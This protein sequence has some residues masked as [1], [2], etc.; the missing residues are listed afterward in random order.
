LVCDSRR[1]TYDGGILR[2]GTRRA[3]A[4]AIAAAVVA[5]TG[6]NNPVL[7][8]GPRL[9]K[10]QA[11]RVQLGDQPQ[12]LDPGQSQYPF[13]VAVLRL[14]DEPLL[15][16]ADDL[17]GVVPGAASSY[18]VD[19][20]GTRWTF[21]LRHDAEYWDGRPVKA[22]DFVFAWRRLIDP[23]LAAPTATFFSNAVFNGDKV[24]IL[25]PQRD[26][27]RIDAGLQSLGLAAPDDYTFQVTLSRPDP[28]FAWIAAMPSGSPIRQDVVSASGDRWSGSPDTL[29]SN[30]PFK[31]SEMVAGDHIT[32]VP[33]PHYW[34]QKPQLKTITY[35][36]VNDGAA[37]LTRF[38]SGDL[39]VVDV[40]PAQAAAVAADP[41]LTKD[42]V[43][44]PALT[45]WWIAFRVT[46][47]RLASSRVRLALAQAIDR[48][49]MV[50]QVFQG[51]AQPAQTFIPQ[52]M[53]GY[54]PEL[55]D[56]QKFDV[57]QA[58]STLAS[59]GV[60]PA[61]LNGLKF[62]YDRTSDFSKATATFVRDQLKANLGVTITLDPLDPNT[63]SSHVGSGAFEI[64]GPYGWTA[65]YPDPA[66][67]FAIF[68]TTN[69]NDSSLYQNGSYDSLVGVAAT[70]M[71]STR[72]MQEYLQA[73]RQLLNDAPAAFLA[74]ALSWHLVQPYVKGL[75][76][77]G[78]E[79]W[80]GEMT[81][82]TI[83]IGQH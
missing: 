26:A 69:S 54:S 64:A 82:S 80:P 40:Q 36:I 18:D 8:Q 4:V 35:V 38:R 78:V 32:L 14:I 2:L 50:K 72:R 67:W 39:D 74:Q 55:A 77:N 49:A 62:S 53:Q 51:Q 66:D 52:G 58:R 29:V 56:V 45:V 81:P 71:Q 83:Y 16:P 65:D 42:L 30:G 43:K 25:D 60:S 12:S 70:D 24:S 28:A 34:G 23:R 41:Q 15:R 48:E 3:I 79:D 20:A 63:L 22:Q 17:S 44:T 68:L 76:A 10:D 57:A 13:E 6:C 21:H 59:A 9:A 7:T 27:T 31:V 1:A 33:N 75:T 19:S 5:A 61:Q 46:A 37:A 73:Q 47:P 11:L